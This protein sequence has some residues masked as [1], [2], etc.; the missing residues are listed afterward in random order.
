[1][2]LTTYLSNTTFAVLLNTDPYFV[3]TVAMA[4]TLVTLMNHDKLNLLLSHTTDI[5]IPPTNAAYS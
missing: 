2:Y 1:M 4:D 3:D 5:L